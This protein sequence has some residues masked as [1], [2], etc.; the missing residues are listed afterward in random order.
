MR[1]PAGVYF[2]GVCFIA[3]S[4]TLPK[5][6]DWESFAL[7]KLLDMTQLVQE[8]ARLERYARREEHSAPECNGGDRCPAE[9]PSCDARGQP[10]YP[11]KRAGKLRIPL[12]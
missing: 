9:R 3:P 2:I 12:C 7:K 10:T 6:T 1:E 5:V 11:V 4:Q 8:Q